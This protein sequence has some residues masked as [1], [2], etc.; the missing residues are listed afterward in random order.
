MKSFIHA[1]CWAISSQYCKV[2]AVETDEIYIESTGAGIEECFNV[3]L[4][5]KKDMQK[6][7]LMLMAWSNGDKFLE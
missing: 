6:A 4:N 7:K 2:S 5:S 1:L 3:N